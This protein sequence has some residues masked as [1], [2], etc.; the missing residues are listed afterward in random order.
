M[1][2]STSPQTLRLGGIALLALTPLS[3]QFS[4]LAV[5]DD[6]KQLYFSSPLL[7]RAAPPPDWPLAENR[8]YLAGTGGVTLFAER[9]AL[10]TC[11]S[12]SDGA[13]RPQVT[14]DGS[15]VGFTLNN[16]CLPST[17]CNFDSI[18]YE[19]QVRGKQNLD[20]GQGELQLSRNGRWASSSLVTR[21][22]TILVPTWAACFSICSISQGPWMTSAKP[23]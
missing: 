12:G 15:L 11:C 23:G 17:D 14:G 2:F 22:V 13:S 6:G 5:T 20:L 16:I 9:G 19:A 21:S 1:K 3:A 7:L 4:Q 8:I 18:S 10:A